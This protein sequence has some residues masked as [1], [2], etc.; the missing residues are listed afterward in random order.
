MAMK[1]AAMG[2]GLMALAAMQVG[3]FPQD[4]CEWNNGNHHVLNF[5]A[6]PGAQ[7]VE[8]QA[9]LLRQSRVM[10]ENPF[11]TFS[12]DPST[13]LITV[14]E[15]N[16]AIEVDLPAALNSGPAVIDRQQGEDVG[17]RFT[18]GAMMEEPQEVTVRVTDSKGVVRE[19]S[20]FVTCHP[21]SRAYAN[22]YSRRDP[23]M[24][25][26]VVGGVIRVALDL[27]GRD[28]EGLFGR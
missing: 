22:A 10:F 26:F 20:F 24:L 2:L 5:E 16:D 23:T 11:V 17:I 15:M 1:H 19:D 6:M 7:G 3:C 21:L 18:C 13:C 4:P 25:N 27:Q 9:M 12:R 14:D 8:A 28:G